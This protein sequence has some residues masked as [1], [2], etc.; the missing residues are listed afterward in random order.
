MKWKQ[1]RS[2]EGGAKRV[3]PLSGWAE[4]TRISL[5]VGRADGPLSQTTG[6]T[7]S[8][9]SPDMKGSPFL[10]SNC[11]FLAKSF[12]FNHRFSGTFDFPSGNWNS[13]F[14]RNV[15]VSLARMV[16]RSRLT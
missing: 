15:N 5:A 2:V 12:R 9:E 14:S 3:P 7:P 6:R 8:D 1:S 10:R 13:H 11:S 16:H 4:L